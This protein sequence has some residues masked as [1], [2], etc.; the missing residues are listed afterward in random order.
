VLPE[1]DPGADL[2]CRFH[3][4]VGSMT[5]EVETTAV[6]SPR[7]D[8]DSFA[9]QVLDTL[10]SDAAVT[11]AAG[12]FGVRFKMATQLGAAGAPGG[13]AGVQP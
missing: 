12:V 9:W 1:A 5:V 11:S 4:G 13:T 7:P 2:T 8:Y 10:A 6:D 3:L